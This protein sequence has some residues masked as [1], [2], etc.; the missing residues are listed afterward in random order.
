MSAVNNVAWADV[1]KGRLVMMMPLGSLCVRSL[2]FPISLIKTRMQVGEGAYAS[3][4]EA[5]RTIV[6]TEGPAALY[7]GF[8][9]SLL[10]LVVGPVYISTLE[11]SKEALGPHLSSPVAT[12]AASGFCASVVAQVLGVPVDIVSQRRMVQGIGIKQAGG[13]GVARRSPLR[14]L[15]DLHKAEGLRGLY[16][17][18]PIS[19]M[20]YS[21]TSAVVWSTFSLV[22]APVNAAVHRALGRPQLQQRRP[23]TTTAASRLS[24]ASADSTSTS[25]SSS[26]SSPS[27]PASSTT[28]PPATRSLADDRWTD[29]GPSMATS[30][31]SGAISGSIAAVATNPL[32]LMRTRMQTIMPAGSTVADTAKKVFE[33]NGVLGFWRGASARAMSM[34]PTAALLMTAYDLLKRISIKKNEDS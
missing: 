8:G 5:F 23:A 7:K 25:S 9:T 11:M 10:G 17:G 16:R 14:V 29:V 3:V 18:Y 31:I 30:L 24:R 13:G 33:T 32:D 34:T 15:L 2:V 27:S 26:S 12:A 20:T 21:P 28:R 22:Q 6:R 1:D 4:P 19:V